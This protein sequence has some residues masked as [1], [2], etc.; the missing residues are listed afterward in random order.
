MLSTFLNTAITLQRAQI[1]TDAGGAPTQSFT[2]AASLTGALW[3]V[4]STTVPT[5]GTLAITGTHAFAFAADPGVKPGDRFNV[6]SLYYKVN[7]NLPFS[8]PRPGGTSIYVV[9]TTILQKS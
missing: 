7:G 4:G 3:P 9:D 6:G 1:A 2:N 8:N 5:L